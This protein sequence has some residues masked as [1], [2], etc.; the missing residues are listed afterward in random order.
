MT[1]KI[2]NVRKS[3]YKQQPTIKRKVSASSCQTPT[4]T[5][6]IHQRKSHTIDP[7]S[8]LLMNLR[9]AVRGERC[10]TYTREYTHTRS[11]SRDRWFAPS[12]MDCAV[13]GGLARTYLTLN[14]FSSCPLL[15][16]T[17]NF[18]KSQLTFSNFKRLLLN[19]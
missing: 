5:S 10:T 9:L 17:A 15:T 11:L 13:P 3:L 18:S 8:I 16:D 7:G 19:Q 4:S 2:I 6:N 1:F 12:L 14:S